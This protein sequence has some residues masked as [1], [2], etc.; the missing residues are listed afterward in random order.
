[1]RRPTLAL[2]ICLIA[3]LAVLPACRKAGE[4]TGRVVKEIKQAPGEFKKGYEQ[5]SS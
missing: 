5:G 4:V 3:A 2:V 1:M